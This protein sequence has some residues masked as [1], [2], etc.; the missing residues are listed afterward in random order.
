[1][2]SNRKTVFANNQ[3]YHVFNRGVERRNVFTS[4]RDYKRAIE[5]IKYYQLKLPPYKLSKFLIQ[6]QQTLEELRAQNTDFCVEII[7]YC[8][9]PNHFHLVLKQLTDKGISKFIS[10]FTNSY[11]RYFNTKNVRNGHLFQGA[12]K[13]VRVESDEQLVH[14]SRYVHINP[15]ISYLIK[16]NDLVSYE[17]SSL[18]EYL[19]LNN[20]GFCNT[21]L[22]MNSF[23]EPKDY[24]KYLEDQISYIRDLENITHLLL[25]E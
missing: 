2:P 13:A 24:R 21:E 17:Y 12:F 14:L 15:V 10:N 7:A 1:M 5:T 20:Q 11:T 19:G 22:V 6:N 4:K 3:I 18:S 23:S 25:E 9:M 8:L 16:V